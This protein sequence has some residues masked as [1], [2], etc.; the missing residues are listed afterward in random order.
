MVSPT[1]LMLKQ[2]II[3]YAGQNHNLE[4]RGRRKL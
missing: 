3:V 1:Y 4:W 2:E